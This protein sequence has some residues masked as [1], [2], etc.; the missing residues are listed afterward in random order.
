MGQFAGWSPYQIDNAFGEDYVFLVYE[1]RDAQGVIRQEDLRMI[2]NLDLSLDYHQVRYQ[3][4][5][6]TQ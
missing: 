6:G 1:W 5:N 2:M 3:R 4:Q